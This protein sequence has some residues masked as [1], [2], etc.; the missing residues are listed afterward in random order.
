MVESCSS[1]G[2]ALTGRRVRECT[3]CWATKDQA[4]TPLRLVGVQFIEPSTRIASP[5]LLVLVRTT[6][7]TDR[8]PR[9]QLVGEKRMRVF[10]AARLP[11]SYIHRI[12][13]PI[14]LSCPTHQSSSCSFAKKRRHRHRHFG[15]LTTL[16]L[17]LV[18]ETRGLVSLGLEWE[19]RQ[20]WLTGASD[21]GGRQCEMGIGQLDNWT[22]LVANPPGFWAPTADKK[23]LYSLSQSQHKRLADLSIHSFG[24]RSALDRRLLVLTLL[25]VCHE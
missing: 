12:L 3:V 9:D 7:N 23:S 20:K 6:L 2:A 17:I 10:D 15:D 16:R 25:P 14:T 18:P 13:G 8:Q 1:S 22:E 5:C 21:M 19:R 4:H 24:L 11:T